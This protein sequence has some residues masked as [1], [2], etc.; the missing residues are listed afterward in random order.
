MKENE[1]LWKVCV[2]CKTFNQAKYIEDALNGFTMQE[3]KFP[4]VCCIIDDAS[5]DGEPVVI[6]NYLQMHFDLQDTSL[7]RNEDN[8]AYSLIFARHK[9]NSQCYFAVLLLKYNHYSIKK[10]PIPYIKE[11]EKDTNYIAYC[12]G[13]DFWNNPQK[14]QSQAD[15][16]DAHPNHSMC[17]HAVNFLYSNGECRES[18]RYDTDIKICNIEDM[19]MT[20]GGYAKLC[21]IFYNRNKYGKGYTEWTTHPSVGD[22]PMQATLFIKGDVAY[23]NTVM[24]T[25][26]IS[27]NSSW[28]QKMM[29]NYQAMCRHHKESAKNWKE[30][31][32][33][34]N[35][36]YHNFIKIQL[37]DNK[38]VFRNRQIE[39]FSNYALVRVIRKIFHNVKR[40]MNF[41][42]K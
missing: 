41:D 31:D 30:F 19:L 2:R 4:Y 5:T 1:H 39:Y 9:T 13:D 15:F 25:Y 37:S 28:T 6:R 3:T 14:L 12:E 17:F 16:M 26:R 7:V 40:V 22:W 42:K 33:W 32:N 11:W 18:H 27:A 10:D 38:R 34:T 35:G 8:D 36:K 29:N 24:S 20:I 23:M 21:S